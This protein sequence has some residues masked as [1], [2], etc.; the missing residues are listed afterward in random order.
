MNWLPDPLISILRTLQGSEGVWMVGGAVRDHLMGRDAYDLDFAVAGDALALARKVADQLGGD[1]YDLDRERGAGR[2]LMPV[3][4]GR[5][6]T[7]DFA[8]LRGADIHADLLG[9]D[10]TIDAMAVRL[11]DAMRLID[12]SGGLQ[13]LRDRVLRACSPHAIQDDPVRSL[14]AVRMAV[15]L[16]CRIER[17]TLRQLQAAA[18]QLHLASPERVRDEFFR[19]LSFRQPGRPIRLLDHLG[20]LTR[21]LPELEPLRLVEQG[22]RHAYP[23]L[24]HTLA[25]V[26]HLQV[27]LPLVAGEAP[28]SLL[29][30]ATERGIFDAFAA[31]GPR[32]EAEGVP[33][34][35]GPAGEK[36]QDLAGNLIAA[37][38]AHSLGRFRELLSRHL[39]RSLTQGRDLRQLLFLGA[40]LHDSGKATTRTQE[41]DGRVRF[42][43]HE[44]AGA[45]AGVMRAKELR[46]SS[47]E[48]RR[49]RAI[50]AQHMRP[51]L[52]EKNQPLD[53]R[54]IYRYWRKLGDVGLEIILLSLADLLGQYDPPVPQERWLKRL[55]TSQCLLEGYEQG[56]AQRQKSNPVIRGDRLA[57]ALDLT[58]GPQI[59][60]LL[61]LILEAQAAGEVSTEAEAIALGRS[62][63]LDRESGIESAES[64]EARALPGEEESVGPR[65]KE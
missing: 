60:T 48:E 50:I 17:D 43:G 27:L 55:S 52:L 39:A 38:A 54:T 18:D 16:E 34:Q 20:L 21:V 7:L 40:L 8:V 6:Q 49:L 10:F 35:G 65:G 64:G 29:G 19:L 22:D 13:D 2:V 15:E 44:Q 26:D 32:S 25:V 3:Q 24:E 63:L 12:P 42:I 28:T 14:R 23:A 58:P 62:F 59:G 11:S 4:G 30:P 56:I 5:R 41:A 1:Y 57:K 46:L 61:E 45:E 31:A 33:G 47:A 53:L 37:H 36:Q 9:R 51:S